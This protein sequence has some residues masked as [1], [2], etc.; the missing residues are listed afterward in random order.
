VSEEEGK[1]H[2]DWWEDG[3]EKRIS[4]GSHYFNSLKNVITY[5]PKNQI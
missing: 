1:E 4:G 5:K 3:R 2:D